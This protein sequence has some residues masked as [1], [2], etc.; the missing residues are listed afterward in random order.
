MT[1]IEAPEVTPDQQQIIYLT[2]R[3]DALR[4]SVTHEREMIRTLFEQLNDH[5]RASEL[6]IDDEIS[7][8]ELDEILLLAFTHRMT[9]TREYEVQVEHTINTTFTITASSAEEAE[10]MANEIGICDQPEYDL[11]YE[12]EV[13][14]W[15]LADTRILYTGEK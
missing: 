8:K 2:E 6:S 9:F 1:T 15:V 13:H 14:E 12:S 5:I 10:E 3:V 4:K 7:L 11:P